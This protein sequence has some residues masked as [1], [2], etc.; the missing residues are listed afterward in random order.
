[1]PHQSGEVI[2]QAYNASLSLG[3]VYGLADGVILIENDTMNKVC[4]DQL[5]IKK[6]QLDNINREIARTLASL[7]FPAISHS[8]GPLHSLEQ[9]GMNYARELTEEVFF[10]NRYLCIKLGISWRD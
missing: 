6:P 8:S 4:I 3:S 5:N 10:D 2:L 9:N 1:M 7:F